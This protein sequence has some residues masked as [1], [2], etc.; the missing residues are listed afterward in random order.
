MDDV[1]ILGDERWISDVLI[2]SLQKEFKLSLHFGEK[3][4]WG[5]A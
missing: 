4:H 5:H 3:A 2:A 1:F